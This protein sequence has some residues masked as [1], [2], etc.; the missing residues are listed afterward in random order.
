MKLL[1]ISL[2]ALLG[3][4]SFKGSQ[5]NQTLKGH[6]QLYSEPE[7]PSEVSLQKNVHRIVIAAT[8]DM[9]GAYREQNLAVEDKKPQTIAVGGIGTI[10][11]YFSILRKQYGDVLLVDSGDLLP[12]E[13]QNLDETRTYYKAMAYDALTFGLNDFNRKLSSGSAT[14][15][16]VFKQFSKTAP[17]PVLLSNLFD[18]KT[19]RVIEW[20]GTKPYLLKEVGGVKVGIIGALAD[21]VVT[22]T[23]ID[24]RVGLYVESMLQN[25]L[26]YSRLL[27]SLGA[28]VILVMTHQGLDCSSTLSEEL[29]LPLAKVNFDPK[30]A[31]VCDLKSPLG[32]FL[33]RLPRGLVDVVASG[34]NHQKVANFVNGI[35]VMST[36]GEGRSFNYVEVFIDKTAKRVLTEKTVVH[37]PVMFCKEFFKQTNDCWTGDSF[38]D[39]K[40]RIP[41]TFLGEKIEANTKWD[42]EFPPLAPVTSL[43]LDESLHLFGADIA[44]APMTANR[45]QLAVVEMKGSELIDLLEEDFNGK[46]SQNWKPSPYIQDADTL[47]LS[48]NGAAVEG[49]KTY[50]ILADLEGLRG[51]STLKR[52]IASLDLK[53]IHSTDAVQTQAAAP[54]R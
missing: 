39:H 8:N 19:S 20:A 40:E 37:Q 2:A 27:R 49:A 22:L 53:T 34:R 45:S 38:V 17:A 11:S 42:A 46:T 25:T 28:E 48:I 23:P 18:L 13:N 16:D 31:E 10:S 54:T 51:S 6:D 24:N 15:A 33:E 52:K 7:A 26:R 47:T 1:L 21:D 50:R 35:L 4:C 44:Y 3:S 32:Q 9:H 43:K 5:H 14:S 36:E 41:A 12:G 30:K 29:K